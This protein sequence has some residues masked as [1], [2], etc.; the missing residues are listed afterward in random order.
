[1]SDSQV[2]KARHTLV[3]TRQRVAYRNYY[4]ATNDPDWDNLIAQGLATKRKGGGGLGT[5][6]SD[7]LYV[8][9]EGESVESVESVESEFRFA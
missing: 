8:L 6:P 3:L 4:V 5:T 2:S 1:M 7:S 9:N